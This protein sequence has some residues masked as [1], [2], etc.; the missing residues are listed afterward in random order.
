MEQKV[1]KYKDYE[2]KHKKRNLKFHKDSR[3]LILE[4]SEKIIDEKG[5]YSEEKF[6]DF[7][8]DEDNAKQII[9]QFLEGDT[10]VIDV[11]L[12]DDSIE[13]YNA[14]ITLLSEIIGDFFSFLASKIKQSN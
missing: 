10:S 6:Y 12:E 8:N 9:E 1:Y 4:I 5:N 11:S 14:L 3:L 13:N 7:I 2:F